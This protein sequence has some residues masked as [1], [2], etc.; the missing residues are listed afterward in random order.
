VSCFR[1]N[2]LAHDDIAQFH[3]IQMDWHPNQR[4]RWIRM[5]V[6]GYMVRWLDHRGGAEEHQ[7]R[8][9]RAAT[10]SV[11]HPRGSC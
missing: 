1:Q 7:R 4:G 8:D 10:R 2:H 9:R 11:Y 3:R 6:W 5:A